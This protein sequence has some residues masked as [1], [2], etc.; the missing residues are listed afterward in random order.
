MTTTTTTTT[1]DATLEANREIVRQYV[2]SWNANDLALLETLVAPDVIDHGAYEGQPSGFVGYVDFYRVW[3][4]GF[5]GFHCTLLDL[6]AE[7]DRVAMRWRFDGV[8]GGEWSGIAATGRRV[9]FHANSIVRIAN[10]KI[11][12]EWISWDEHQLLE[13]VH[14][15]VP[16]AEPSTT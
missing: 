10:G 14:G 2:A 7:G 4:A 5:P 11:Q 1:N 6:I 12:E 9:R 15:L 3:H 13:Q 8:H 16:V